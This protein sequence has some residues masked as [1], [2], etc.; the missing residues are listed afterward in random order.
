MLTTKAVN[1][2]LILRTHRVEGK[3][4]LLCVFLWP[5]Q[6][7]HGAGT[8]LS[9]QSIPGT[10]D[11]KK[12]VNWASWAVGIVCNSSETC[13]WW[14][15]YLLGALNSWTVYQSSPA[16]SSLADV[17]VI[18]LITVTKGPIKQ[19]KEGW[20]YFWLVIWLLST[21]VGKAWWHMQGYGFNSQQC[22]G[23]KEGGKEE[24]NGRKKQNQ[25]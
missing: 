2:H 1:L 10:E 16:P 15:L 3:N 22:S 4:L 11:V 19:M 24:C 9:F 13:W 25:G 7:C 23:K 21:L 12:E 20:G 17:F 5:P 14:I 8:F 6:A 18:Y